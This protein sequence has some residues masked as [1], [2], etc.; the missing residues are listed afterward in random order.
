M[1]RKFRLFFARA[2]AWGFIRGRAGASSQLL[3]SSAVIMIK[4]SRP[5]P[6]PR[7]RR[8]FAR[9][10]GGDPVIN[11]IKTEGTRCFRARTT[12]CAYVYTIRTFVVYKRARNKLNKNAAP[13]RLY[14]SCY[15]DRCR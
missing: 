6:R 11:Q 9:N 3:L 1:R 8:P 12:G 10:F 14:L 7:T 15:Y 4:P 13:R 2:A 5:T